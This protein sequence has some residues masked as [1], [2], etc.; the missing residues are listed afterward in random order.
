M[1]LNPS[2]PV[3]ILGSRVDRRYIPNLA[4]FA[5]GML[6]L[7]VG[8]G[9]DNNFTPSFPY[10]SYDG[11]K[12][13][14][15]AQQACARLESNAVFSDGSYFEHDPYWFQDPDEPE[16]FWGNAGFSADGR[17]F[18]HEYV[19]MHTTSCKTT[20]L[21]S[22][23]E[24]GQPHEPW[25]ETVNH[26]NHHR[27]V[28]LESVIM[29]GASLTSVIE[30]DSPSHLLAAGYAHVKGYNK[31]ATLLFDSVDGG[32]TWIEQNIAITADDTPE[33]ADETALIQLANGELYVLARTG[34]LMIQ[35]RSADLGRTWAPPEPVRLDDTGEYITGVW[36]IIRRL[37]NGGLVCTYGRPKST[38]TSVEEAA[39]FD[40]VAEHSG[41]CGKFVM[42]DPTGT[43][44][45]W[46]GRIDLHQLEIDVQTRNGVPPEQRLRVQEDTNVR[47]SN[48]WEY[49]TLN[50]VEDDVL[51]VTYDVQRFREN[52]NSHPVNGVRMV[53]VEVQR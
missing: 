15:E 51:L 32:R 40:Y 29:G 37:R 11:G 26:A 42:I 43:G 5:D 45:H 48:S 19:R 31:S 52:W 14:I 44:Q 23:R 2:Q 10:H 36:P 27:S 38:F 13:W 6:R 16:W 12:T 22:M 50:E 47:D 24:M 21:R 33:G 46:Q 20:T 8:I 49:L 41:H 4:N 34:A 18:T 28:S 1:K 25:F 39:A 9:P 7:D 30:L 17:S 3:T 53:R 35:S